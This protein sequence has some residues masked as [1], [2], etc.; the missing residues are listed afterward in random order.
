M[1]SVYNTAPPTA[2]QVTLH[3]SHGDITLAL[4]SKECPKATRNFVQHC[5]DGYYNGTIFHRVVRKRRSPRRNQTI[6]SREYV[7]SDIS[8]PVLSI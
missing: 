5:M 4:W 7:R 8:T 1:S 6:C 2:G 3:T